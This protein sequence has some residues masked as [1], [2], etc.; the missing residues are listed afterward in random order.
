MPAKNHDGN[1]HQGC[2]DISDPRCGASEPFG[3]NHH[4]CQ[5]KG[6][7]N[8]R[9]SRRKRIQNGCRHVEIRAINE[10]LRNLSRRI[11]RNNHAQRTTRQRWTTTQPCDQNNQTTNS[12]HRGNRN[13]VRHGTSHSAQGLRPAHGSFHRQSVDRLACNS[14]HGDPS[15]KDAGERA[16]SR[17]KKSTR[18]ARTVAGSHSPWGA[19]SSTRSGTRITTARAGLPNIWPS[20]STRRGGFRSGT[21]R[22][23]GARESP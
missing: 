7:C 10:Q 2:P 1:T 22:V 21:P 19:P 9:M 14:K 12:D 15:D 11:G 4:Q 20:S 5:S 16:P 8:C 18:K 13:N 23:L 6:H 3:G 17:S